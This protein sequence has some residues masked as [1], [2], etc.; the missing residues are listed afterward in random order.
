[1]FKVGCMPLK[2]YDSQL[3]RHHQG[4]KI[5]DICADLQLLV[6]LGILIGEGGSRSTHT[7]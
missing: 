5:K 4:V 6:K 3:H 2:R 7:T 1:M